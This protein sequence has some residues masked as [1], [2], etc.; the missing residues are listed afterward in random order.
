MKMIKEIF[1]LFDSKAGYF[2]DPI[3]VHS[4]GEALRSFS[5]AAN[6]PESD[7]HKHPEDYSLHHVGHFDTSSGMVKPLTAPESLGTALEYKEK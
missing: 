5:D 4:K 2:K 6:N 7:L 1:A 3:T